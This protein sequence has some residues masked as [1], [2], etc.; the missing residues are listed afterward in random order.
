VK[1]RECL[2]IMQRKWMKGEGITKKILIRSRK[3]PDQI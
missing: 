2:E 1:E 3:R